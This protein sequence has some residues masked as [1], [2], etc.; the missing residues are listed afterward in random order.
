MIK[1][2]TLTRTVLAGVTALTLFAG[3]A[4]GVTSRPAHA[5]PAPAQDAETAAFLTLINNYRTQNGVGALTVDMK[6][7]AASNWMS[8]DMLGSGCVRK[9]T[10]SHTDTQGHDVATRLAS[11]G[12]TA[13][14]G[15]NIYGNW[16]SGGTGGSPA[17][18]AFDWWKQSPG[19]NRNMLDGSYKAIGISRSCNSGE[20]AWVTNFGTQVVQT[21][22]CATMVECALLLDAAKKKAS[23]TPTPAPG[24]APAPAPMIGNTAVDRASALYVK[25][26]Q[27]S[28]N[29]VANAGLAVDGDFGPITHNA[30]VAFQKSKG[31]V[32]DGIVG[33]QTETALVAAG[34]PNPPGSKR[35]GFAQQ[36]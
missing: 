6:L 28:L 21:Q 13:P 9:G 26:V 36:R 35:T 14:G 32:V 20:C 1:H 25:W 11:F 2:Q 17:Q 24:P 30:V 15:E 27:Q 7:Q 8:A 22:G 3:S 34:A 18:K 29:Q 16:W 19:H 5:A 4:L 10:C 31:L 23:P 12:Y 33:E